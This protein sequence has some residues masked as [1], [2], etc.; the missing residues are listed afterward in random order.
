MSGSPSGLGFRSQAATGKAIISVTVPVTNITSPEMVTNPGVSSTENVYAVPVFTDMGGRVLKRSR[1]SD[2]E[3]T[4]S[5]NSDTVVVSGDTSVNYLR[6]S[7]GAQ[8]GQGDSSYRYPST[9]GLAGQFLSLD[10]I[11]DMTWTE[12][13]DTRVTAAENNIIGLENRI[14]DEED[15]TVFISVDPDVTPN[16]T[17]F[18]SNIDCT[19][20]SCDD[21]NFGGRLYGSDWDATPDSTIRI[22]A[23]DGGVQLVGEVTTVNDLYCQQRVQSTNGLQIGTLLDGYTFPSTKGAVDQSLQLTPG[24]VLGWVNTPTVA[25][26]TALQDKTQNLSGLPT[27]ST[28]TNEL[29]VEGNLT[30][31]NA[32]LNKTYSLPTVGPLV[33]NNTLISTDTQGVLEWTGPSNYRGYRL[34]T[35]AGVNTVFSVANNEV[36]IFP[37]L[38][39]SNS[40]GSFSGGANGVTYSGTMSRSFYASFAITVLNENKDVVPDVTITLKNQTTGAVYGVTIFEANHN[41][42][43]QYSIYGVGTLTTGQ[44]VNVTLKPSLACTLKLISP[45]FSIFAI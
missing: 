39:T 27:G 17:S 16:L 32:A 4:I 30:I 37:Y 6:S 15:K 1:I 23:P 19:D 12:P 36:T 13:L 42:Q 28:F 22:S 33:G 35:I 20:I 44:V 14:T 45:N 29:T 43:Q 8:F 26:V 7:T 34:D 5:I 41:R 24:G 18:N 9:K 25:Q 40:L 10:A 2:D 3:K 38:T 31:R 21:V 11:G